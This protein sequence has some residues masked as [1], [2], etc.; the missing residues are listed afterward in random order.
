MSSFL[1]M[2]YHTSFPNTIITTASTLKK[3][4]Q[5]QSKPDLRMYIVSSMLVISDQSRHVS[6]IVSINSFSTDLKLQSPHASLTDMYRKI[7]SLSIF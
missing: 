1:A 2:L 6:Q 7:E 4:T 5:Q 3:T